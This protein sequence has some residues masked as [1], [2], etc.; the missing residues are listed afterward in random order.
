MMSGESLGRLVARSAELASG[1]RLRLASQ[2]LLVAALVFVLLR[3][4]TLWGDTHVSASRVGW[5]WIAG[6]LVAAV[7]AVVASALIWLVILRALGITTR[8]AWAGIFLQA[9]LG[10]YVPGMLW[11]YAGRGALGQAHGVPAKL[12][13]RSLPIELGA[14]IYTGAAFAAFLLGWWGVAVTAAACGAAAALSFRLRRIPQLAILARSAPLYAVAWMLIAA[15]FWMTARALV[16]GPVR[17]L[18]FY[19]GAFA[20]A[21]L[22]GLVAIYAPGGLGVREAVLVA[23]LRDRLG[24]ADALVVALASRGVFTAGDVV[25]AGIGWVALRRDLRCP[26]PPSTDG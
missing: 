9:Q 25:A 26:T 14:T 5:E 4:R 3:L 12:V 1:R 16:D 19:T 18:P 20:V 21:W 8:P 24:S 10:K 23:L 13:A 11:Q 2:L 15:S 22:A 6:A 7:A 17:D